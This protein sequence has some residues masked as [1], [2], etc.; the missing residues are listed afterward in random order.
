[1]QVNFRGTRLKFKVLN[2]FEHRVSSPKTNFNN[3]PSHPTSRKKFKSFP[4]LVLLATVAEAIEMWVTG[5]L[6]VMTVGSS[7][8]QFATK[9]KFIS[10]CVAFHMM[11]MIVPNSRV[12]R[13]RRR[14][15]GNME[16]FTGRES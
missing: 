5:R 9:H 10:V 3:E 14:C 12:G 11:M 1:M 16:E 7:P 2:Q 6:T 4:I 8:I 15:C 13:S